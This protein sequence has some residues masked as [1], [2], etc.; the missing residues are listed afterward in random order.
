M[1]IWETKMLESET[2]SGNRRATNETICCVASSSV[3]VCQ[4]P[5][6]QKVGWDGQYP[7]ELLSGTAYKIISLISQA[8]N[9]QMN[10]SHQP[11]AYKLLQ[12]VCQPSPFTF[13]TNT[14]HRK[15]GT[16]CFLAPKGLNKTMGHNWKLLVPNTLSDLT[17]PSWSFLSGKVGI[18]AHRVVTTKRDKAECL[19]QQ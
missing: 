19:S 7:T 15:G 17:T 8:F 4:L 2:H 1:Q 13:K 14:R 18:V 9:S 12:A 11:V 16:C 5:S 3:S 10:G 6:L